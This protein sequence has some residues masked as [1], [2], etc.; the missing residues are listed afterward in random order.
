MLTRRYYVSPHRFLSAECEKSWARYLNC[1]KVKQRQILSTRGLVIRCLKISRF[2]YSIYITVL[3]CICSDS[4]TAFTS[5]LHIFLNIIENITS[6]CRNF[7][8]RGMDAVW[9]GQSLNILLF[10]K[11]T[12][13]IHFLLILNGITLKAFAPII[14]I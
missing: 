5:F 2:H 6:N 7:L 3:T 14:G 12:F 13:Q 8:M 10:E 9:C 1:S 11:I 4:Q